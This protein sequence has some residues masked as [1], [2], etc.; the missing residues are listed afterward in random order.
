MEI[1][2]LQ[3]EDNGTNTTDIQVIKTTNDSYI[4]TSEN[5]F[6]YNINVKNIG[7]DVGESVEFRDNI[8]QYVSALNGRP[9]TTLT[10]ST[11]KA[12]VIC[13]ISNDLVVC[14]LG[15][16]NV[17]DE[18]IVTIGVA[19]P[20]ADGNLSNTA[21]AYSLLT[22]DTNRTNNE[23]SVFVQVDPIAD[24]ELVSKTVTP[25]PVLAGTEAT[26]VIQIRNNG[27]SIAKDINLSD[28]FTGEV[29]TFISA[30]PTVGTCTYDTPNRTLN[31]DM[32]DIA[33]GRTESI[34][35]IIRPD[36]QVPRP[37]IWDINNTATVSTSTVESNVSNNSKTINLKVT[38]GEL[39]LAIEKSESEDFHEPVS[40]D[41]FNLPANKLVYKIEIQNHGPSLATN[42]RFIDRVINVSPDVEQNLTF[43]GDTSSSLGVIDTVNDPARCAISVDGN[44]TPSDTAP[45]IDCNLSQ[46]AAGDSY[47]RYLVFHIENA[48]N[49]VSGDVYLDEINVT[50]DENETLYGNN[51]EDERTTVRVR[52]DPQIVKTASSTA[53]EVG[54][55][56]TYTL[57]VTNNGPGYS[58]STNISDTLPANMELTGPL[59]LSPNQGFCIGVAGDTSF[60]CNVD[61]LDG[62]LHSTYGDPDP[63]VIYEVTI[64]V[65]VRFTAYPGTDTDVNQTTVSNI[66]IVTTTG[67][68]RNESN[69]ESNSTIVVYKPAKIGDRVWLDINADGR[70]DVPDTVESG[71]EGVEVYLFDINDILLQT[72][73]TDSDG[74]YSFDINVSAD[75]RVEFNLTNVN[76][77]DMT[78]KLHVSP[79]NNFADDELDSD[80]NSSGTTEYFSVNYGD[81]NMTIDAGL[82]M[83]VGVGDRVWIDDNGNGIQDIG[84]LNV[85][86][87][88]VTLWYD[89]NDT[90]V[91]TEFDGTSFG[92]GGVILT[93][94]FGNYIFNNLI[95]NTYYVKF[96]KNTLP[97]LTPV[98]STLNVGNDNTLD[99]DA[100]RTTGISESQE[101]NASTII[102]EYFTYL[103]LDAGIYEPVSIG[104][105][106][107]HDANGDGIQDAIESVLPNV[108]VELM[109]SG[110]SSLVTADQNSSASFSNTVT[111]DA[112]GFYLFDNLKPDIYCVRFTA[113]SGTEYVITQANQG[114]DNNDSDANGTGTAI[115]NTGDYTLNSGDDNRS[116]DAGFYIPL[117]IGNRVW[118]D[119]NYNGIQDNGEGNISG[120]T[121][122]LLRDGVPTGIT[123]VTD[124]NGYLFTDLPPGPRYS[125]QFTPLL[126]YNF[127]LQDVAGAT[128]ENDSDT[129][130]SGA[131]STQTPITFSSESNL[132][133]DAGVY[134]PVT[135]GDYVW[136]D[137]DADGIQEAGED[138]IENVTVTL[139][140]DGTLTATTVTTDSDGL[141][142]FDASFDL[143]PNSTY[144][145][146]FSNLPASTRPYLVTSNDAGGD[147][148]LDSDI[149]AL[150]TTIQGTGIMLS[151]EQNL[152][153]DA[154]F[155]RPASMGNRIWYD[156][157]GN[158][159]QDNAEDN[160]SGVTVK[161]YLNSDN[162]LVATNV[163]DSNGYYHFDGLRP[164][165]YYVIVDKTQLPSAEYVFTQ[166]DAGSDN[167]TDSDVNLSTG[168]SDTV[169]L[170]SNQDDN[171]TDAGIY[172]PVSIGDYTWIDIN[173]DGVSEVGETPLPNTEVTLWRSSDDSQVISDLDATVFGTLGTLLTDASGKYLFDNLRPDSYYV[174][175]TAPI[176][177]VLSLQN[178]GN[179]NNDSDSDG[180]GTTTGETIDYILSSGE[181]NLSVDAGFYIAIQVGDRVWIDRDYNGIQDNGEENKSGVTV[182]LIIDSVLQDGSGGTT[183]TTETTD[184]NGE[185]LFE[186][187]APGHT[188][189]VKFSLP[190]GF[191]FTKQDE[192]SD[193]SV[194][195][196][197]NSTGFASGVTSS[198]V[199]SD[200]NLSF[201]AGV[202]EPVT[203]GNYVWEDTNADG[204]QDS[205]ELGIENVLVTLVID[206]TVTAITDSTD[207]NGFYDF[208]ASYDLKPNHTYSVQ[209]SNLPSVGKA[210]LITTT[211]AGLDD[212]LDS[213]IVALNTTIQETPT[214]FSGEDNGSLDAGFYR[215]ASLGNRVW[216]DDNANGI[217]DVGEGNVSGVTVR[218]YYDVNDS[219]VDT[220]ITDSNGYYH[221]DEL[222]PE[223]YYVVF[224]ETTLPTGY[225]FTDKNVSGSSNANN[226]DVNA[227]G[228]SSS[229]TLV[230]NEDNNDTDAGIYKPV[231]VGDRI[232]HDTNANGIQDNGEVNISVNVEVNMTNGTN[233]YTTT[234]VNGEYLFPLVKPASNYVITF[235]MPSGYDSVSPKD[236]TNDN[237]DSDVNTTTLSTDAFT[238]VSAIDQL[239]WDMGVYNTVSVG[240]RVWIDKN[241]DGSQDSGESNLSGVDVSLYQDNVATGDNNITNVN[242]EYLFSGLTPGHKYHVVFDLTALNTAGN[243][244]RFTLQDNIVD[245]TADSDANA[246]T[247]ATAPTPNMI[248]GEDNLTLDAGVYEPVTIGNYVWEDSNAD[249]IQD[250]GELGIENVLVTLVIDGT[251]T[252]ITDSTDGNGFYDFNASYDLKPNH[253]YSVQFSN[254]PSVGKAYLITT[255]DAGLDDTL[256]SD[257]VAL[258]TTIQETPTMFSGEDNGS[259]D[260][261]FYRPA[262]LGN[263]VWYDDNANGIQDVG[264][265]NVSGVT[266][267][268]YY[269]VNNSL[270]DTNITD[271]NGYYHFDELRPES[272][273]V[274]F[275]ETTLPTGYIFTDK[276]V[277]GSSNANNSD[278]NASGYSS[279]VTLVSNE[280][281]ND[282]DAGI[283]KPVNVGDRIWH[284]TNA[285]GI[286]D[287]GE[288]N[289]SVNVEV[290]MT[291]GTNTYTTT[292]VNGSYLFSDVKPASGY[293]IT[294]A[295]PSGYDSVSPKDTTIDNNDSDVNTTTLSTDAFT[296]VSNTDQLTWDMGI[297]TDASI[298]NR[299]W[300]DTNADGIQDGTE[301][302]LSGVDV[303]VTLYEA[304]GTVAQTQTVSNGEY[305][306]TG[307]TPR[308]YYVGFTLPAGYNL[309]PADGIAD[310]DTNSDVNA[311]GRTQSTILI[312]GENDV[313]WDM[314]IYTDASIGN[315]IWLDTNADGIQD[316]TE[317][318]LSGVD[319]NVTLYEANGTVAQTQ[320]VNNG[321]YLFTGITPREYYVGFTLPAGY[322]LSPAD[323]IA[324]TDTNSDVNA[325]GRT[326]STTLISGENDVT[327]D[328]GI[329]TDAS[330]GNRIWLDTNAD[331]IQDGT[332]SNLSGVDVNVTLYEANGTVAQT[333]TVN[334]G[335][336]LFTGITPREYYVGFTLP[337]GYNLSPA[338]GIADTDTNSDVNATGRT[339][340]TTLISGEND[341]TWDMGIYTDASIG[342]RIWLDTNADGIQDGTESNLSGVDVNVTLYEANGTVAQTQTVSNGAYLFTGITPRE[343]YVGF[344]LPAGYNLS[345]AD[346][347]ADTDT[348][349]DVNATG[350]T[351]S[352]ILISGE[353][354]VTWDMGIYTDASIGN[355]IW[356]DTNADGIQDG[357]E[358]NLSGVDVNVTLYEANG[359]VAQTQTVSNGEYLFTGITPREY[360]VGFTLP[361]GYN[362]SPADGI[363]DTDTNS[364]V[365][366]TGRTQSTI[367][368]SGENDVTWDMGIYTDASI[369][370]RIWLDTNADGFQDGTESNLSGVDVNVT[371]YEAN[372][373]VAQT[374]TVSNGEYLFTGITPR[375]YYVGFTLPAGYNLSPADGIADTDTNSDVNATGR[376][377]STTLISG[378]ND[379]T[380]DMGIYTDASIGNRIWLDTNADGI[381]DGTESNLSGVDVNVTLYEANGTVAQTQTVNNGSYLF[382]GITPREYYVG[383]TLPA[384]YN[385]SPAD[386]IA[387]TDTN[388]DVNA[389]GRTQSTTLISGENDVT[390]DMGIYTDASIGNRIWLDTNAD[391]IQDGTESNLSGV[392]VNVTLYEANGTV[393]QTQTVNNGSYLFT[394]ITP[395]E[396]YVGFTLP[397]GYN[398]SPA[399]GIA[400][401]DTNSDVNATGRTQSTI[402]I[403]GENDVTWD[404]GIYTD[405]SIGNRI[406]LD[407]NADGIQDGTE[408]N[409]SGVD[410]N[411]TLYEANGTVAQTQTVSNG[412]YLFTGITPREYYV[413]FTLPAGYNLS[414]ADGIADTDT[415]SD[416]NATG[417]TQSTTLI[418]GENDVT[419]DMGV[420][421]LASIGDR[422]WLDRNLN[423]IQEA[424]DI[425]YTGSIDVTLYDSTGTVLRTVTTT[426]GSYSF[427]GLVPSEYV[428]GFT[429]P[430][431]YVLG[432]KD[433][434]GN[435]DDS[436]DSDVNASLRTELI[437]LN[438]GVDDRTWDMGIGFSDFN[439][440]KTQTGGLNPI[441]AVNDVITYT[442]IVT[443]IGTVKLT[444][445]TPTENYPGL[446]VGTLSTPLES[447]TSD[448]ILELGETWTYTATYTATQADID[449]GVELINVI[450]IESN[451]TSSKEDNESTAVS[452]I[453]S[454]NVT[455]TQTG[456]A[457]PVTSVGDILT[458][459]IEV[460]NTGTLSLTEV[461]ATENYPGAGVGT[462][463]TE[464]ESNS[465]NG[466]LDVGETWTYTATYTA[467][468]ADVDANLDLINVISIDTNETSSEDANESTAISQLPEIVLEK[469]TNGIDADAVVDAV[470]LVDGQAITWT[471]E[472]NNTG[473][474]T[475]HDI[476]L[477][478]NK[479]GSITCPSSILAVGAT[480]TC[481]LNGTAV[482]GDYE[483]IASVEVTSPIG[484]KLYDSDPSHYTVPTPIITAPTIDVEKATN[485]VDADDAIDAVLLNESDLVTWTY[486]V[487]NTGDTNLSNISLVDDR[488]GNVTCPSS[489]LAVGASMVCTEINSTAVVGDYE[490]IA[491]VTGIDIINGGTVTDT[492]P[493]HYKVLTALVLSAAIDVEKSTNGIDADDAVDAV[494]LNKDDNITWT[495]VVRNTGNVALDVSLSDDRE[496]N[497]SCPQ[498]SLDV[499]ESMTCELTGIAVVGEYKNIATVIGTPPTGADVNDSDP[500]HYIASVV[501]L[502]SV[503][504]DDINGNGIQE[505]TEL[506]IAGARVTLVEVDGSAVTGVAVQ[507]TDANGTYFFDNLLI[508]EY[509]VEVNMSAVTGAYIP[510][511][512]QVA[513]ANTDE[514]NDSN[515]ATINGNIYTSGIV[516]LE[517]NAEPT[518]EESNITNSGD[519]QDSTD[520][521][522][523]NMT[524]DFG[525]FIAGIW[526]GHVSKDTNNDT[527]GDTDFPNVTIALYTDPNGDGNYSDDGILFDTTTTDSNGDYSFTSLPR[528][529][530]VAVETQP[531]DYDDVSENEGGDDDDK[532]DNTMINTI[533]GTIDLGET[534]SGNDFVEI[535]RF[536]NVFDPPSALKT[537]NAGGWP[538]I[539]WKMVWINDGNARA[540]SVHVEDPLSSDLTFIEGTLLC[541]ARGASTTDA[542][543]TG[544]FYDSV[545]RKVIWNGQ[546]AADFGLVTEDT[547]VN[548]VVITFRT[549][550]PDRLNSVENQASANWDND[551]DGKVDYNQSVNTDNPETSAGGRQY[552]Y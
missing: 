354:D 19:R 412:E 320:T 160:V 545:Q 85:S 497:V 350:R 334:N 361:A 184:A 389:T 178:Q 221:F 423:G 126:G 167:S 487:R 52:T 134:R 198:V 230:S 94:A 40:F 551:A 415:N 60:T 372:G 100:N 343:Y 441:T 443:N 520:D 349:S 469:S 312:S 525:F 319:V 71:I 150:D 91:F 43:L 214:M 271:S 458:Y 144:S 523:G 382:T 253:T 388:S 2:R 387:D 461:N 457:N 153:L 177:Y 379:V 236:T 122:E 366:A 18:V 357:T 181:D 332:E 327:W 6:S 270:V 321:S 139:V 495:Y 284:D 101:I 119:D 129:N 226:S 175:F 276:N 504:W 486:T 192:G 250:S 187:L 278:V 291:N 534:D 67:P 77:V 89:A 112:S 113:P 465:T 66:A 285:N 406:W 440:S 73:S 193:D 411:V 432:I 402:L 20:M 449:A 131:V 293:V 208:N 240:D 232:W 535:N 481:T 76:G 421:Q 478:D 217:Q 264:E 32:G 65:P 427:T 110:C 378:E 282:T 154:G 79:Q 490:N 216:Y 513:D 121:V 162:S 180:V 14:D 132:S 104:D 242:G 344:T 446:G 58:P 342:N 1:S 466:I 9:A 393:A 210:Y 84:E 308:E 347:I 102:G 80:I 311:T 472:M 314:G 213:D 17:S 148:N 218:L 176:G 262:S 273:Y 275:D 375:E 331:G 238:V 498:S 39:D 546:I 86:N 281:N 528:G 163:T 219:L 459:T 183:L 348:N 313:T 50:S 451:Q 509:K 258:N 409:L 274:V 362:L 117:T 169:T 46:L 114:T 161:L 8:P 54:E 24:I 237:N 141:Y 310:T 107:W 206:G 502:G 111:T 189:S 298:G 358:S 44:F 124:A 431:G 395:R 510:S 324:D 544:C 57:V 476:N 108:T 34:S 511:L 401:T 356:L 413:G 400:D 149:I 142:F 493:S 501:S 109:D 418:S 68:D 300:L 257:I 494:V 322:N 21:S 75:Y 81:N 88:A 151:G 505:A 30:S 105:F 93:D 306:F 307:I 96:D 339:Q 170:I 404:M 166:K 542:N 376:T 515:I 447:N 374:Q 397:A 512:V 247:G 420:Y 209:F 326:Q 410:V 212:T 267:R 61:S 155:Y 507:T 384:G 485:G 439:V 518:S 464:V 22:G 116:V 256:D 508:G 531:T 297:Y 90:Q 405:A 419:W 136:E 3:G 385:L 468:Q 547:A 435:S 261:G 173:G 243:N 252:A 483:N 106:A 454:F 296:V 45:T 265:G 448:S 49:F 549:T 329:Y 287:N 450:S 496:G 70:Q 13:T 125:V 36:E 74:L 248:S 541:D 429:L 317:S 197:V 211:D 188:Y 272:Y 532:P 315:R 245:D 62:T 360:Y 514:D 199:S 37:L 143:K 456:G 407:T 164:N 424:E 233:T 516:T 4:E 239:T 517:N 363:A 540:M 254:L 416:V 304:N 246:T 428:I 53:V 338:D 179:D 377:Q 477:S 345:P 7:V 491:T 59:T 204:I 174:K 26:Y 364:D 159:I 87:V 543:A 295:M 309:S 215:P 346:G 97:S 452:G 127:T 462:L 120:M 16:M 433:A 123:V 492:D 533:A 168:R 231:N 42:L 383:F 35:L 33:S 522:N 365:N 414:P 28:V 484:I 355:R 255:T 10:A 51:V 249:G 31:C 489:T 171:T 482:I 550:V 182:T 392:D 503:V 437:T 536:S 519:T 82:Y 251:V 196:D 115:G 263:R 524:V 325:T 500:S 172:I 55:E 453:A 430:I 445:I 368:I 530:Y 228:Y 301:S 118:E 537:G 521:D 5:N 373:T 394:G 398:L 426:D 190:S 480:M 157:N 396:Y 422:I 552:Y 380:W 527:H 471:Y 234:A 335:S 499:G 353:N 283:Y 337:A 195:S 260:A 370:N 269:D 390:W 223:S 244:Y 351:Q 386:G 158:G 289:I 186:T 103:H 333:Q 292:A 140:V 280:D 336:Y 305:L 38:Y 318:N 436:I 417:R 467:T 235:A 277:S 207:G 220:N 444:G 48:P 288:V 367:L 72:T 294:F 133:F 268:L 227:S 328:M 399:D 145:V 11:D 438:S 290:S 41:P 23:D 302:N 381:Q 526:T 539:E 138:G 152:S 299:I 146:Q 128:D 371:L 137:L 56:F 475:L 463:G 147:D 63:A 98:F 323:G 316:G 460:N 222:R 408:S 369:G 241:Y 279:S 229:V 200:I 64:T 259:L 434:N 455:K 442:I 99:S 202:Y 135:I 470:N 194:D 479:E 548:E 47:V 391:G 330:I 403:S 12:G 506:G 29:F 83:L 352:T 165:A 286:Q 69:N 201:D 27:P 191:L 224:D 303:N 340:S 538:E 185:Y 425:N 529:D 95:P 92:V 488:E 156:D 473:N 78:G 205:G 266:V 359:T 130:A 203:I 15:D 225:I 474:V 25:N 341:V